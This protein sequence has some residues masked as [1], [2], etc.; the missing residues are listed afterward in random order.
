MTTELH[1]LFKTAQDYYRSNGFDLDDPDAKTREDYWHN[2][3][4]LAV[5]DL[6]GL[7]A[8]EK[9]HKF[10]RCVRS[11]E[12]GIANLKNSKKEQ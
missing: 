3:L 1:E 2:C 11:I 12:E 4:A 8:F 6:S 7:S 5:D 9:L 10:S